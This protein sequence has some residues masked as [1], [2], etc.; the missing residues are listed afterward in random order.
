MNKKVLHT[1]IDQVAIDYKDRIAIQETGRQFTY[2]ALRSYSDEIAKFLV[3]AGVKRGEIVAV[4]QYSSMEYISSII[5]VNKS[6]AVFMPVEPSHPSRRVAFMFN[7][8]APRIVLTTGALRNGLMNLL[9]QQELAIEIQKIVFIN[10]DKSELGLQ[11]TDSNALPLKQE[12]DAIDQNND[13]AAGDDSNYLLFTSGSTGSP[14]AIEGCHKGLSHFIHWEKNEF[15]LDD[16]VRVSQLAPLSFDVSLRDIFLPLVCGGTLCIPSIEIKTDPLNLT[17]WIGEN[18]ITVMHMVPTVFRSLTEELRQ[19]TTLH[20]KVSS[21]KIILLAGEALYGKDLQAWK[22]VMGANTE[23]VN[24]YG[25]SETT[26]AKIFNRTGNHQYEPN[27][28]VP[29]GKPITN[30]FVPIINSGSLCLIGEIGEIHIKTPF[31]SKGYYKDISLTR[32]KF[33]QNPLHNDYEDIIYKTGDLGKYLEDGS[34]AFIGRQDS[35]VKIRGN[36]VE[37]FE[38]EKAIADFTAISQ[39]VVL[40]VKMSSGIDALACYYTESSSVD[41]QKLMQHLV[42]SLPEYMHPSYYIKLQEFPVNLNGKIDKRSLPKPE[43]LLYEQMKYEAPG[44]TLETQLSIVW[45]QVLGLNKVGIRN[46]FFQLGGHSLSAT[47]VVSRIYKD[48]GKELSVREFFENPTISQLAALLSKKNRVNF[49]AISPAPVQENYPLSHAQKRLWILDQLET[50]MTAYNMPFAF[51]FHGEVNRQALKMAFDHLISRHESLRTIFIVANGEPRQKVLEHLDFLL[52]EVDCSNDND[53][54]GVINKFVRKQISETFDISKGPLLKVRL[55]ALTN[56]QHFFLFTIHHIISDG[57]SLGNIIHEVLSLYNSFNEG[58]AITLEPLSI[59]YKDYVVWLHHELASAQAGEHA[60]YWM[61]KLAGDLSLLNLPTD[62]KRKA[63]R[64]YAGAKFEFKI[65]P[66]NS[67][68]IKR[69][70]D[71]NEASLFMFFLTIV[72]LLLYKYSGQSEIC[73]GTPIA[74][75]N[76]TELEN[77]IGFYLNNLVLKSSIGK[78]ENFKSFLQQVKQVTLE[79]FEHQAYPFDQL[80]EELNIDPQQNRNPVY[81]V[82]VVMNNSELNGRKSDLD[83]LQKLLNLQ[84]YPIEDG[85]SKLDLSF[86]FSEEEEIGVMIEYATELFKLKTIQKLQGDFNQILKH[87]IQDEQININELVW[88]LSG[89]DEKEL[90]D[91][92]VKAIS[93][94]F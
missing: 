93:E 88:I 62:Y 91:G 49:K 9:R 24:M 14:K 55:V 70:C 75:R 33:I 66:E 71:Q 26:L 10:I 35:Q 79:A 22:A 32:E 51:I 2:S 63:Q 50:G 80:V 85:T 53:P 15:A 30:T 16:K 5:G 7:Q 37:L 60:Q 76:H 89:T 59:Q 8:T 92:N 27:E 67:S 12:E 4:Y 41:E 19:N 74:G 46:S 17:K 42:E 94:N 56:Q 73:V 61:K 87:V 72:K 90:F 44:T 21:V 58:S 68:S 47:K 43:A 34:I 6:G 20:A 31:R 64:T 1:V 3:N 86:F 40:P 39:V 84:P 81:D 29:L 52:E 48:L 13:I 77:Q 57:W 36:R 65:S 11:L 78:D 28:I 69:I 18:G 38:V 25:P 23:L 83:Q 54:S 45:S 82:L